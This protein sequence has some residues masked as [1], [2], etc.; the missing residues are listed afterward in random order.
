M[1]AHRD[2]DGIVL[3]AA[4]IHVGSGAIDLL[5]ELV[6]G[7]GPIEIVADATVA[8]IH[9]VA[10]QLALGARDI[11]THDVP[12]GEPAKASG[13]SSV[14]GGAPG[15][16]RRD[17]RRARWRLHD[18]RRQASSRRRTCAGSAGSRC[19]RRSS[20]R[21]TLRSAARRRST[22]RKARTSSAL[23][24]GRRGLI[25]PGTLE[26]LPEAEMKNGLAEVV[27]T[28]L[29]AGEPLWELATA[30]LVRRCAAFKAAVCLRDPYE[31]GSAHS[32]IWVT[33]SRTRSRL[34][35]ATTFRT[36]MRWRSGCSP[37]FGSRG[38]TR[39]RHRRGVLE[40]QPGR[41]S[42]ATS[43]GRRSRATRRPRRRDRGSSCSSAPGSRRGARGPSRRRRACSSQPAS[44]LTRSP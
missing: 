20:G 5:G 14:S 17:D 26:T 6:P 7:S 10:A 41:R 39:R 34:R 12:A 33:R 36:V 31:Q 29:L 42:T 44:R 40:P 23:S 28:G 9:G 35:P 32:S 15:R 21:S 1:R 30:E 3:A 25:D 37:R 4:G 11:A 27:K 8:G 19:R 16:A 43:P 18:R 22:S 38:T 2:I 24:T 13:C